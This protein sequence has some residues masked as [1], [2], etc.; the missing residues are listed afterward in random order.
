[1]DP[2]V[3]SKQPISRPKPHLVLRNVLLTLGLCCSTV[4][5]TTVQTMVPTLVVSSWRNPTQVRPGVC[6]RARYAMF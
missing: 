4:A 1:M 5:S 3:F 2:T 6:L